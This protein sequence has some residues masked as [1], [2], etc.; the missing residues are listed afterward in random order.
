MLT[1]KER[2]QYQVI[3]GMA[4]WESKSYSVIQVYF[5]DTELCSFCVRLM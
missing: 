4:P 3:V 2:D 1:T 5:L